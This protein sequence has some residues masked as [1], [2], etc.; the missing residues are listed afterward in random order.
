MN[1]VEFKRDLLLETLSV[2]RVLHGIGPT[3]FRSRPDLVHRV[4]CLVGRIG[5]RFRGRLVNLIRR[6]DDHFQPLV[7]HIRPVTDHIGRLND[8]IRRLNDH[9]VD[10]SATT[11][12][13]A[14]T[15]AKTS[16]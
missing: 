9:I 13:S 2:G 10:S 6:L 12:L 14:P 11:L 15:V 4:E 8:H 5:R 7:N 16:I 3:L 1:A